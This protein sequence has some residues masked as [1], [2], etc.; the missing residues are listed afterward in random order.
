MFSCFLGVQAALILDLLSLELVCNL[1]AVL[2][3]F[4]IMYISILIH[5]I[6]HPALSG[7]NMV[8]SALT[9]CSSV[10]L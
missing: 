10:L 9:V 6:L 2:E 5:Y 4:C 7:C 3:L 1:P 8:L